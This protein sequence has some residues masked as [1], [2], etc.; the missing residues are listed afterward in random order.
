MADYG[1]LLV[2]DEPNIIS[3]LSRLLRRE[4]YRLH[5]ASD[6]N[7]ALQI[8]AKEKIDLVLAD[9]R[10]PGLSGT[11]LLQK[12]KASHPDVVRMILSGYTDAAEVARAIN[13]GEVFRFILKPWNDE[14]LKITLR[15]AL[16][17]R[18][19][20]EENK[21][22]YQRVSEQNEELRL[23]NA[24]LEQ[25]VERKTRELMIRNRVLSLAQDILDQLPAAVIGVDTTGTIVQVNQQATHNYLGSNTCIGEK[26]QPCVAAE[27][28]DMVQAT[29][30]SGS[31]QGM[32]QE[33]DRGRCSLSCFPLR[34]DGAITGAVLIC[35]ELAEKAGCQ[36]RAQ[37]M[38]GVAANDE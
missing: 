33:S 20:T 15:H 26:L 6:G 22:L 4:H 36:L 19:L 30:S 31:S 28:F 3:S 13:E 12:V 21:Q 7:D 34:G 32:T 18:R 25:A 8:L 27:V 2:D 24:N 10:M 5:T 1:I 35:W 23:L 16:E 14:E 29:I 9:G 38:A 37:T 11:E 17:H